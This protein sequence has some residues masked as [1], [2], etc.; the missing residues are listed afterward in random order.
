MHSAVSRNLTDCAIQLHGRRRYVL[1]VRP[2]Y[3]VGVTGQLG[4]QGGGANRV[5]ATSALLDL[6]LVHVCLLYIL[7]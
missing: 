6:Q 2:S 7:G 3:I 4:N 5:S 1:R